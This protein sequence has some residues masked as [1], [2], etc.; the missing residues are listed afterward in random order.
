MNDRARID[1]LVCPNAFKGSLTAADAANA[2]IRGLANCSTKDRH[3]QCTAL[4]LADG[5]DGILTTLVNATGGE[6]YRSVVTGPLGSAVE[7]KWGRLGGNQ[8]DCAV[9]EMAE[10]S[11]LRLLAS[12]QYDAMNSSTYGTGELILQALTAGCRRLL[13]GIGGSAT[14][15]GGAGVAQALGAKLLDSDGKELPGTGRG[16]EQVA[17][18]DMTGWKI[19]DGVEVIVA[20]DVENPLTGDRG[21]SAVYGPQKGASIEQVL[22]LDA[23]LMRWANLLEAGFG[24]RIAD[25]QGSGAAGGLGAGLMAFLNAR[26]LPGAELVLDAVGFD[27]LAAKN[28]LV[29]TGEGR[30]DDQTANG[31]LIAI[32]AAHAKD[33]GKPCI[34][35]AGSIGSGVEEM[36]RKIGLTA[37]FSIVPGPT[38][39]EY[40]M[41]E[42][43]RLLTEAAQRLGEVLLN[44]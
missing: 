29:I 26:L 30:L 38:T 9:I 13:I 28:D 6:I 14:N 4:P 8:Q 15:D 21:A 43:S 7:A 17:A 24:C 12:D 20:C 22:R 19:P 16:L 11:G 27:S 34:G 5:G 1:V 41:A 40:A 35:L 2:I 39:L 44:T 18:I 33:C 36:L 25:V 37:A 10:A 31:K 32:V 42:S 23:A 3:F